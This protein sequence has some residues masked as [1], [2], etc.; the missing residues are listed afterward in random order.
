MR[1]SFK[2]LCVV[3]FFFV[4]LIVGSTLFLGLRDIKPID[5]SVSSPD[6][7]VYVQIQSNAGEL[8]LKLSVD[9]KVVLDDVRIDV[10][11]T[12]HGSAVGNLK[13]WSVLRG[14]VDRIVAPPNP[15]V[16]RQINDKFNQLV[17]SWNGDVSFEMRVADDGFAYRWRLGGSQEIT[18]QNEVF[19]ISGVTG[20]KLVAPFVVPDDMLPYEWHDPYEQLFLRKV[21][22][23]DELPWK[24]EMPLLMEFNG[25]KFGFLEA[26]MFNYPGSWF[27]FSQPG[28]MKMVAPKAPKSYTIKPYF[29]RW[30]MEIVDDR[31]GYLARFPNG[32]ARLPWRIVQVARTDKDLVARDWTVRVSDDSLAQASA[33]DWSWV[34]PGWS[35]DEWIIDA[36]LSLDPKKVGFT[37]GFNTPTYK[38]YIDFMARMGMPYIIVDDGWAHPGNLHDRNPDINLEEVIAYGKSKG[39][40]IL[41]WCQYHTVKQDLVGSFDLFA[42]LGVA[43]VKVDFMLRDDVEIHNFIE[44]FAQEAAKRK[45]FVSI[46]GCCKSNGLHLRYP[47]VIAFEGAKAHEYNKWKSEVT[48]GHKLDLAIVRAMLPPFDYEGGSMRNVHPEKF[49]AMSAEVQAQGTRVNE[50][51]TS[52][53]FP[54]GLQVLS[55]DL[56]HYNELPEI[57]DM[58]AS[59]PTV[60]DETRVLAAQ[61]DRYL[62]LARRTGDTWFIVGMGNGE[63]QHIEVDLSFLKHKMW[64][65]Y[66]LRDAPQS[67]DDATAY[68]QERTEFSPGTLNVELAKNGGY[69]ARLKVKN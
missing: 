14:P 16:N 18:V 17:L 37:P 51:A 39:V 25:V 69:I 32:N 28:H 35:T 26:E 63:R 50:V 61:M 1:L 4:A 2:V 62:I 60:W 49:K 68:L 11:T 45:L 46:H 43:G 54:S 20:A 7:R 44:K 24:S 66:V 56:A 36:K 30:T 55:G 48:P 21:V 65:G 40:G 22:G 29:K 8:N 59:I 64:D 23:K 41:L 31:H 47:N 3:G 57:M 67:D 19:T 13:Y 53:M 33:G 10:L 9:G 58:Y 42:K 52:I 38:Y 27:D 6:N 15:I 34:K 12:E 5:V